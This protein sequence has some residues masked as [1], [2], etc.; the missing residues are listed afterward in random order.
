M[1][2]AA[3]KLGLQVCEIKCKD[4]QK[5]GWLLCQQHLRARCD[6][7]RQKEDKSAILAILAIIKRERDK[8]FWSWLR[9][10]MGRKKGRSVTSVQEEWAQGGVEEYTTQQTVQDAIFREVHQKRFFLAEEAPICQGE[11]WANL[12][13][14]ARSQIA[15]EILAG[16]NAYPP[17]FDE[18]K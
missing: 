3:I 6:I 1:T 15:D 11:L 8:S 14:L 18:A 13:Y 5:T 7:A 16:N 9:F 10:T 4:L 17:D 12:G 2:T